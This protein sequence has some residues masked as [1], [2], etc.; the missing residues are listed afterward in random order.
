MN[1]QRIEIID[2]DMAGI[3]ANKTESERL[4]IAWGM[5]RSARRMLSQLLTSENEGWTTEQV[6]AEV[7]RRMAS[8]T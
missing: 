5:W 6:K 4:Q 1:S 7:S 2:H 3:L 8:G